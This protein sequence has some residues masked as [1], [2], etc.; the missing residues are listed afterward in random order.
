MPKEDSERSNYIKDKLNADGLDLKLG[1]LS[2][3]NGSLKLKA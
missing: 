3:I 2:G 1:Y